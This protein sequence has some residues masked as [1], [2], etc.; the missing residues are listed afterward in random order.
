LSI[1]AYHSGYEITEDEE[2]AYSD[3]TA[4]VGTNRLVTSLRDAGMA[5]GSNV[6]AELG[7]TWFLATS[8]PREAA[9]VLGKMLLAVGEDNVL[10]G[11]DGIWYGATQQLIDAFRAFQIPAEMQDEFG[12]PALTDAIKDKILSRNAARIYGLD[13]DELR[14]NAENDDLRWLKDAAEHYRARGNPA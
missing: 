10:W 5:P 12:Y 7:S 8:R 3:E 6:Y 9:H 4:H 14:H 13:V 11:T 2:G 1:V